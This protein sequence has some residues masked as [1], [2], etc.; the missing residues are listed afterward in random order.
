[1]SVDYLKSLSAKKT[2]HFSHEQSD[3]NPQKKTIIVK[4][5]HLKG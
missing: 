1:M 4:S 5:E 3:K 2:N